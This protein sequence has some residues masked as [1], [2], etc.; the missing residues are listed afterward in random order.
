M[1]TN[2]HVTIE[3]MYEIGLIWDLIDNAKFCK[4]L[5]Y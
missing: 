5:L 4:Q 2:G 1:N 3:Y